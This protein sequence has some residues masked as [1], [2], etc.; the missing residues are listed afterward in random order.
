MGFGQ[1]VAVKPPVFLPGISY[2]T[3][4]ATATAPAPDDGLSTLAWLGIGAAA[5][6][7]V[8][9]LTRK[10][11][12]PNRRRR[13]RPNR[14]DFDRLRTC[15]AELLKLRQETQAARARHRGVDMGLRL[16]ELERTRRSP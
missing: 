11:A 1:L 15:H 6:G 16:E 14:T 3:A 9:L 5:V 4:P 8:W 12:I 2:A 10:Q 7:A 13:A